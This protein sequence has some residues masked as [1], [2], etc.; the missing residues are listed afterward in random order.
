MARAFSFIHTADL[1]L[2]REF[3]GLIRSSEALRD[4]LHDVLYHTFD[5]LIDICIDKQVDF[6]V[7]SGDTFDG[8]RVSYKAMSV[9]VHGMKRLGDA[10]IAVYLV[11]GNH[12]HH[13]VWSREIALLPRNVHVF[14]ADEPGAFLH[15][16][17]DTGEPLALLVGRSWLV[18]KPTDDLSAGL[19]R[20]EGIARVDRQRSI[21]GELP[22]DETSARDIFTLGVLHTGLSLDPEPFEI[23][24]ARLQSRG[25]DYWALGHI[26][27][28]PQAYRRPPLVY[29]GSPQGMQ[30][31]DEGI[32][33]CLRVQVD[34]RGVPA[35]TRIDTSHV[36]WRELALDI[37]GCESLL[38]V[39][40]R[41]EEDATFLD[42]LREHAQQGRHYLI[43]LRLQGSAS[44]VA[45][46]S[47]GE[48][49]DQFLDALEVHYQDLHF[50]ELIM[51]ARYPLDYVALAAEGLFPSALLAQAALLAD[52]PERLEAL[53]ADLSAADRLSYSFKECP[54]AELLAQ[55][56]DRCLELLVDAGAV[57]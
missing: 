21:A 22:L 6:L 19:S 36:V 27:Q 56:T 23:T 52:E 51:R 48:R 32:Q 35:I 18:N 39:E 37:T 49:A 53:L 29:A 11:T 9:F 2:G 30:K 40:R 1:H 33:A 24:P 57:S 15:C 38:E 45:E 25:I 28:P 26:H 8:Q 42:L 55:A 43:R 7:I 10:G 31:K 13:S 47:A 12:D 17:T 50:I 34:E 16:D 44:C 14:P 20:A 46:L 54:P 3:K 4:V 41:L 5:D